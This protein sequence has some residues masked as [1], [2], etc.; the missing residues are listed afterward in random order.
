[1]KKLLSIFALICITITII[2]AVPVSAKTISTPTSVK[3]TSKAAEFKVQ[4][5]KSK[6]KVSGYK[7]KYSLN[8][9]FSGCKTVKISASKTS[10][11]IKNLKDG[12]KYYV[13][14]CAYKGSSNSK[15]TKTKSVKT[16]YSSKTMKNYI[17]NGYWCTVID[18]SSV[19]VIKFKNNG[20]GNGY[21]EAL[22]YFYN[23]QNGNLVKIDAVD[24]PHTINYKVASSKLNC[25]EEGGMRTAYNY[26][27]SKN[28]LVSNKNKYTGVSNKYIHFSDIPTYNELKKYFNI[29]NRS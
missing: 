29:K 21:K 23:I 25:I 1:M 27:T 8:K 2:S 18:N 3:L 11:I 19:Y 5:K 12:K 7:I 6:S 24:N 22:Q 13:K 9:N 14:V 4:F 26:T 20:L 17:L 10:K 16:K 28:K 15:W